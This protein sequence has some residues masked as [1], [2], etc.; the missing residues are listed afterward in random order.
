MTFIISPVTK[1]VSGP[2]SHATAPATSSGEHHRFSGIVAEM[3]YIIYRAGFS[4]YVKE[5]WD[6][7]P[8]LVTPGGEIFSFSKHLGQAK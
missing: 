1:A 3:G 8:G 5:T 7:S 2:I 4:S 6:F